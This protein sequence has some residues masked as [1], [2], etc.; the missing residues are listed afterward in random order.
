MTLTEPAPPQTAITAPRFHHVGIQT[1]DLDNCVRW[2][3]KLLGCRQSWTLDRFSSLTRSR[4][5]GIIRLTELVLDDLRIH[6]FERPGQAV[7]PERSAVAFQHVCLA[8]GSPEDLLALRQRC[9]ELR[10]GGSFTYAIDQDPT[11]IVVDVD[12]VHSFYVFDV[13]GLELE[14]TWVPE[15]A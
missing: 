14:F 8:A 13:N 7:E 12:G 5:P 1:V 10:A 11:E 3:Q 9:F 4:L 15:A 2:Y 6:V